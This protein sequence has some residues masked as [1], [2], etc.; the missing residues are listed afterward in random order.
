MPH[1][2]RAFAIEAA[3]LL[4]LALCGGRLLPAGFDI[5]I[6]DTYFVFPPVAVCFGMAALL[7][8]F[9]TA[10]SILS[11]AP[12]AMSCHFWVTTPAIVGFWT[13]FYLWARTIEQNA[14]GTAALTSA[15][16]LVAS[17]AIISISVLFFLGNIGLALGRYIRSIQ[18]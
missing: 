14:A 2:P 17:I 9:A 4:L 7:C 15:I 5:Q 18:V 1:V 11:V 12:A 13:S 8:T 16:V 3:T 10:Y 6:H